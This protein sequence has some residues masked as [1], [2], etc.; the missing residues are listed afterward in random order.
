MSST[1]TAVLLL[2]LCSIF[3]AVLLFVPAEITVQQKTAPV[4]NPAVIPA[5]VPVLENATVMRVI[6]MWDDKRDYRGS[7]LA[8]YGAAPLEVWEWA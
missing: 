1:Q 8:S 7:I 3:T 2:L 6:M 5:P 4:A